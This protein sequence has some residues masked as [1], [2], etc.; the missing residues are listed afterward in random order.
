MQREMQSASSRIWTRVTV[1]I[2]YDDY[3]STTRVCVYVYVCV[4]LPNYMQDVA[5]FKQN[6]VG[7]NAE[8]PVPFL[9]DWLPYHG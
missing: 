2:S 8:F 1:S 5:Q 7:F 9:L 4:H 6:K 3:H